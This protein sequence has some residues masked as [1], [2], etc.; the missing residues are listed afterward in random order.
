MSEDQECILAPPSIDEEFTRCNH[1]CNAKGL[2]EEQIRRRDVDT[3]EMMKLY[4]KLNPLWADLIWNY[5]EKNPEEAKRVMENKEW[6]GKPTIDRNF[7]GGTMK[8]VSVLDKNEIE[9]E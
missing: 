9:S 4:P 1:T 3:A 8:S 2:T 6:E 7:R 5:C